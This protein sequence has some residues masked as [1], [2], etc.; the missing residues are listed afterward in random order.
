MPDFDG[1]GPLKRG[2]AIGRGLGH[3]TKGNECSVCPRK[4]A[5]PD[6]KEKPDSL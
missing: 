2:R 5:P 1:A 3:C 6:A 4:D